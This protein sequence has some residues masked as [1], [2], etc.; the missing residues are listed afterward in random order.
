MKIKI[1]QSINSSR[2]PSLISQIDLST[3]STELPVVPMS[4]SMNHT[5]K[6]ICLAVSHTILEPLKDKN[7]FPFNHCIQKS[8]YSTQYIVDN[9]NPI[10]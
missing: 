8:W 2:E 6:I 7:Y 1:H 9:L 4:L 3:T 10:N 5:A